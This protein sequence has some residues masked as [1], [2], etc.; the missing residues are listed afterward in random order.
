MNNKQNLNTAETQQLNIAGVSKRFL[1]DCCGKE[2]T[3]KKHK[4]YDENWNVQRGC[5]E[6]DECYESRLDS[7][8]TDDE[9]NVCELMYNRT[10]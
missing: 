9:R 1:C 3:G 10:F 5:Y 8:I 2:Q 7:Q 6:C 4:M